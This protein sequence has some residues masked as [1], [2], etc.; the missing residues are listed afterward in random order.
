MSY[1]VHQESLCTYCQF[2]NEVEVWSI[3]NVNTDPELRD[4]LLGGELNMAECAS[5]KQIFYAE[6]FMLYHDPDYELMAFVYPHEHADERPQWE[7]KTAED[8]ARTQAETPE[9]KKLAYSPVTLFG[10]DQLIY[11]VE[12]EEEKAIQGEIASLLAP[13]HGFLT[14]K[15]KPSEAREKNVPTV[16]PYLN[17]QEGLVRTSVLA[18]L[19]K[20]R[21]VNDRLFVYAKLEE[22]LRQ[23]PNWTFEKCPR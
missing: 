7:R 2:P 5:C 20:L 19:E 12:H 1:L 16:I 18:A 14:R 10:L 22:T 23:N 11:F 8:F 21:A 9:D 17:D 3:V 15:L 4:L 6:H 13:A